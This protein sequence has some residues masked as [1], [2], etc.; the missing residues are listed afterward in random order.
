ML[1]LLVALIVVPIVE[2]A[3]ILQVGQELGVLNTIA[4][5]VLMSVAGSWLIKREG[6]GVLRRAQRALASGRMPA[7]ELVDGILIVVAGA[8][9]LTPGFV[10]DGVG[11]ALLLP[12]VRAV[13]RR[14]VAG[15]LRRRVAVTGVIDL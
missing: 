7:V 3:V 5:L 6:L 8:L 10:T 14:V 2:L 4:L 12:P 1:L 11:F 13:V 15:R 9:L